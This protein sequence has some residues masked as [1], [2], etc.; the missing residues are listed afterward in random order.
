MT[1]TEHTALLEPEHLTTTPDLRTEARS[2]LRYPA[3]R[4]LMIS[5]ATS[6]A[7]DWLYNVALL[8]LVYQR[9][10]S[11]AWVSATTAVRVLPVVLL[12][13]LGGLIASRHNRRLVMIG[14]DLARAALMLVLVAV[15]AFHLPILLVPLVAGLATAA[16]APYP[17]AVAATTARVVPDAALPSANA[18]RAVIGPVSIVLGPLAGAL[19]LAFGSAGLAF[20]V[21]AVTFGISALAIAAL[22]A[23][24]CRPA[25][26][27][28]EPADA[29]RELT[30]GIRA[31]LD[32]RAALQ[33]V[34]ADLL[35]SFIYGVQT[36]AL[37]M[38]SSRLGLSTGGYGLLLAAVGAGGVLGS[39]IAARLPAR[40]RPARVVAGSLLFAAFS[41]G[42]LATAPSV[43][44]A[45]LLCTGGGAASIIVEVFT[46]TAL[47]RNL[48]ESVYVRAYGFAFPA[49]IGGIVLGGAV[50]AP[51]IGLI[52]LPA[53]LAVVGAVVALYACW[54]HRQADS[55]A[56]TG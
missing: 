27:P 18:I 7:G 24:A 12:G 41:I 22:P 38:V 9:T 1:T 20:G 33:L 50:A 55:Q 21:N 25:G 28:G 39:A 19:L 4:R 26:N 34:N 42:L 47:Q 2:A 23:A 11:A 43:V 44:L 53:M 49:S 56:I 13:P 10:H 16:G 14:C 40:C 48:D 31:L 17:A 35:C 51:L 36:V 45:L 46:E 5:L 32:N 54:L 29:L 8:G 15:A 37:L 30:E 6:Q 3:F 52:G